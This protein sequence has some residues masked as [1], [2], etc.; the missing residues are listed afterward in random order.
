MS[1]PTETQQL[2]HITGRLYPIWPITGFNLSLAMPNLDENGVP[3]Y[4][5]PARLFP[6]A[7]PTATFH[8]CLVVL[9]LRPTVEIHFLLRMELDPSLPFNESIRFHSL[10]NMEFNLRGQ[11]FV[12]RVSK[13][14]KR[15]LQFRLPEDIRFAKLAV[16]GFLSAVHLYEGV[17]PGTVIVDV[18][19]HVAA[20]YLRVPIQRRIL[21]GPNPY[22]YFS[23]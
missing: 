22:M 21:I 7:S 17:I 4:P 18:E 1:E 6:F 3:Q 23:A 8:D 9:N 12:M 2:E 15:P 20:S 5:P 16:Y 10:W 13:V 14:D 11:I 19:R